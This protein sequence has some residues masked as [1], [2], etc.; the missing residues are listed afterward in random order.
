MPK[1]TFDLVMAILPQLVT[2]GTSIFTGAVTLAKQFFTGLWDVI[3]TIPTDVF[4]L[5][6]GPG[7][8]LSKIVGATKQ[9]VDAGVKLATSLGK[10]FAN[11]LVGLIEGALNMMI[12]AINSFKIPSFD[13]NLGPLGAFKFGGWNGFGLPLIN[14]PRFEKGAWDVGAKSI[15]A[16]LDPHE[17]VLPRAA[18]DAVRDVGSS[19]TGNVFNAP[20]IQ[21]EHFEGSPQAVNQL[22]T[23]MSRELRLAGAGPLGG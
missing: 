14:L 4:N 18:A 13:L 10:G 22:M 15:L 11:A 6:V 20:L 2:A 19:R 9:L 7:G 23:R 16:M 8:L 12:R 21:I 3:K 5:L 17:M 1:R